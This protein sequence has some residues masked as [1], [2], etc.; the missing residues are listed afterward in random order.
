[1]EKG[2]GLR[3]LLWIASVST[4]IKLLMVPTYHSTDFEVHRHWLAI[5]HSLPLKEWYLDETSEWTLDYPPFFPWFEKFLA[6]FANLVDPKIVDLVGGLN[7]SSDTVVLFQRATVMLADC[8]LYWG[9]WKFCKNFSVL[10]QRIIYASVILSPGLFMVDHIHFQYNGFLLGILLLSLACLKDGQDLQGGIWFAVLVCFK[11]LFAVAGPV[12]FVY[13][14]RHYCRGSS[15]VFNFFKLGFTVLS[16]VGVAFGPFVYYGQ[17]DQVLK[18]MFPFGRGLCHAYWAPNVWALYNTADKILTVLLRKLGMEIDI[19][20]AGLTGGLVGDSS[21]Y[22]V[23]PKITPSITACLVL[24]ALTPCLI[25]IWRKP[26]QSNVVHWIVYAYTCGYMFG[27]HVHEKAALHFL[28]PMSLIS[29]ESSEASRDFLFLSTVSYY[30]LFPLLFETREYP[31]KVFL[32][33]LYTFGMNIYHS[34]YFKIQRFLNASEVREEGL[35]S[36]PGVEAKRNL[37]VSGGTQAIEG[38]MSQGSVVRTLRRLYVW[39]LVLVEIY[40]QCVHTF[41]FGSRL[42]FLPLLLI[43]TYCALGFLYA[44]ARHLRMLILQLK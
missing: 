15:G 12:Y 37:K 11:H 24:L 5:T 29:L 23:L 34:H 14:L 33:V 25:Q 2:S 7:Y 4:C 26:R 41:V 36:Q 43:S 27:W 21:E 18:R 42:P 3:E 19:P 32:L 9:L 39:N 28:I 31:I 17:M 40:G 44:W 8:V 13:L 10:K 38:E 22:A 35:A 6:L 1:M 20:K 16:V 30:S